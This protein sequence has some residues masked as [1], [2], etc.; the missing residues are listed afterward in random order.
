VEELVED[1]K[2]D[3]RRIYVSGLSMGG[4]GAWKLVASKPERFAALVPVCGGGDPNWAQRLRDV[5]TWAFHGAEDSV[6]SVRHTQSMV[7]ALRAVGAPIRFT[8]YPDV[9]HESWAQT[10]EN[11]E[12]YEWLLGQRRTHELGHAASA[13]R[14]EIF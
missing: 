14:V 9:G 12:L 7:D 10:Y 4:F 13:N 2:L 8:L 5:P 3:P 6:V 11:P 1:L